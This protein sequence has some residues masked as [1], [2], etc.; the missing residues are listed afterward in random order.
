MCSSVPLESRGH[1]AE[2]RKIGGLALGVGAAVA[3]ERLSHADVGNA[4]TE[5]G[6]HDAFNSADV[7]HAARKEGAR[8]ARRDEPAHVP[9]LFEHS[10][11]DDEGT[12]PLRP[13]RRGGDIVVRHDLRAVPH[14]HARRIVFIFCKFVLDEGFVPRKHDHEILSLIERQKRALHDFRGGV[15]AAHRVHHDLQHGF[16]PPR[17]ISENHYTIFFGKKQCFDGYLRKKTHSFGGFLRKS[18]PFLI[19]RLPPRPLC[20]RGGSRAYLPLFSPR[21]PIYIYPQQISPLRPFPFSLRRV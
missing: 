5:R 7:H 6:A 15:V 2:L 13:H 9:V 20:G 16:R 10:E 19:P 4:G 17:K 3:E 18:R 14:V 11:P 21:V 8:R 12:I 1:H